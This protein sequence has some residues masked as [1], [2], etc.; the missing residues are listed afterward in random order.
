MRLRKKVRMAG[1]M[2]R[3]L[4]AALAVV[5]LGLLAARAEAELIM[6]VRA[7]S[8]SAGVTVIDAKDVV[9]SSI[10]QTVHF[11]LWAHLI[12]YDGNITN[13]AIQSG[14]GSFV[15]TR[16]SSLW[17]ARGDM[18]APAL[19]APFNGTASQVGHVLDL[20]SDGD[21]DIGRIYG[22]GVTADSFAFRS[23]SMTYNTTSTDALL[24]TFDWTVTA[25]QTGG[26]VATMINYVPYQMTATILYRID[27][28]AFSSYMTTTP[29]G[30]PGTSVSITVVA[31]E[32]GT[33]LLAAT[34]LVGLLAYAWRRRK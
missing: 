5:A 24:G 30:G 9:V 22:S 3:G 8:G 26:T 4:C 16:D 32:P 7:L 25:V 14:T 12:G 31:P 2:S 27:G 20:N 34:G 23:G 29:T 6:D 21:K 28:T 15:E 18:S 11:Q 19:V 13:E 10:G 33:L 1:G 17:E